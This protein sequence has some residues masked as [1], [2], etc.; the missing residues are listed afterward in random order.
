[1]VPIR[2]VVRHQGRGATVGQAGAND[3]L[4]LGSDQTRDGAPFRHRAGPVSRDP[5][6]RGNRV[7]PAGVGV[8]PGPRQGPLP[9]APPPPS[10]PRTAGTPPLASAPG[11]AQPLADNLLRVLT[12]QQLRER[13]VAAGRAR[14]GLY[15]WSA[16]AAAHRDVYESVVTR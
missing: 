5:P 12:D 7:R 6:R 16:S 4:P 8:P 11:D 10:T 14:A 2:P 13:Q 1:M 3:H 9:A 15:T